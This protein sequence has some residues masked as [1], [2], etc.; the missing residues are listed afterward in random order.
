MSWKTLC[1]ARLDA[2]ATRTFLDPVFRKTFKNLVS[3]KRPIAFV[4]QV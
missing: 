2:T 4:V 3:F 1:E